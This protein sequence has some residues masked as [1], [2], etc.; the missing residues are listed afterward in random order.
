MFADASQPVSENESCA[1]EFSDSTVRHAVH[2]SEENRKSVS[3]AAESRH[4]NMSQKSCE[5]ESELDEC[6]TNSFL[7][8][9]QSIDETFVNDEVTRYYDTKCKESSLTSLTIA[10][11]EDMSMQVEKGNARGVSVKR[12][13][14]PCIF[15][16]HI[17]I[18]S[19]STSPPPPPLP[20]PPQP[21]PIQQYQHQLHQQQLLSLNRATPSPSSTMLLHQFKNFLSGSSATTN[22]PSATATINT[23]EHNNGATTEPIRKPS[24]NAISSSSKAR[25]NN[26]N[27]NAR[28]NERELQLLEK[29]KRLLVVLERPFDSERELGNCHRSQDDCDAVAVIIKD[30][31]YVGGN[32]CDNGTRLAQSNSVVCLDS[33][34]SHSVARYL[35]KEKH[36][37]MGQQE[38]KQMG[39]ND[40]EIVKNGEIKVYYQ[41][42]KTIVYMCPICWESRPEQDLVIV[43]D[44][45][46]SFCFYCLREWLQKSSKCPFDCKTLNLRIKK[47]KLAKI[48]TK[49]TRP[50]WF[51]FGSGRESSDG[52]GVFGWFRRISGP[53]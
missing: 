2:I 25:I 15:H 43:G 3:L 27:G 42:D 19:A 41:A 34:S 53:R 23:G 16:D 8:I 50:P 7:T 14:H 37:G 17:E 48:T 39:D 26:S 20:S 47:A 13:D 45:A 51:M 10:C 44:C 46:H 36:G 30:K 29:S 22:N 28:L 1:H 33:L 5:Q 4:E 35:D 11:S 6:F 21:L 38:E 9:T 49:M 31:R 12:Q 52:R 18:S 24:M 32:I 40:L